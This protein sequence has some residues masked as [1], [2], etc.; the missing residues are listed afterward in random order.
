MPGP[1]AILG[2]EDRVLVT[3]TE[4]TRLRALESKVREF[5]GGEIDGCP[6]SGG[7][8]NQLCSGADDGSGEC[9]DCWLRYFGLEVNGD[10]S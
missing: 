10:E 5:C 6:P 8:T 9:R 3:R 7:Y 1:I 2:D 4:L